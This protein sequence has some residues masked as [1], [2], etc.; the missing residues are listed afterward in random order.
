MKKQQILGSDVKLTGYSS[1]HPYLKT[2]TDTQFEEGYVY[3]AV[4]LFCRREEKINRPNSSLIFRSNNA[5][6]TKTNGSHQAFSGVTD[7]IQPNNRFDQSF[8][9][10]QSVPI[11][12][13]PSTAVENYNTKSN[14]DN[15][16]LKSTDKKTNKKTKS[17]GNS[18][19]IKVNCQSQRKLK[20]LRKYW[21][22][23]SYSRANFS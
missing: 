11:T 17:V 2:D 8:G 19:S 14:Y 6:K 20:I 7:N 15:H 18:R 3:N 16:Q 10:T 9:Q 13:S 4:K 23:E 12:I 5:T 1:R 21:T 22:N